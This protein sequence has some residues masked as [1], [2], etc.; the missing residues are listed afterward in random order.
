MVL[1]NEEVISENNSSKQQPKFKLKSSD[2]VWILFLGI[3]PFDKSALTFYLSDK[4]GSFISLFLNGCTLITAIICVYNMRK[5][6]IHIRLSLKYAI[7]FAVLLVVYLFASLTDEISIMRLFSLV[8]VLGYYIFSICYYKNVDELVKDVNIALFFIIILS[9]IYGIFNVPEVMY[10]EN[11]TKYV[12][13]GVVLNRNSYSEI[14][15]FY[16]VTNFYL[17]WKTNKYKIFRLISSIIAIVT[18]ILTNGT[19]SILCTGLLLVLLLGCYFTNVRKYYYFTIF[20]I[21]YAVIFIIFV[22][23]PS[24]NFNIVQYVGKFLGKSETLTGR[25]DIWGVSLDC[26]IKSAIVGYGYDTNILFENQIHV[27]VP[28]NGILH[29]LLTQGTIGLLVFLAMLSFIVINDRN[30][31]LK[32]DK[33]YI[34]M[35][36][37]LVVWLIKGL[38]ESVLYYTH[39]VFWIALIIMELRVHYNKEKNSERQ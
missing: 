23:G 21:A 8:C 17:V 25:T 6:K 10:S 37:F 16:L 14:S 2:F 33:L 32:D 26:Y 18:T 31:Q 39:F 22:L 9:V 35:L 1:K 28:H 29:I 7:I 20:A 24:M 38:V 3:L 12:F 15:L 11:S 5:S 27:G 34:V 36:S 19:T 30:K 4:I 13:K